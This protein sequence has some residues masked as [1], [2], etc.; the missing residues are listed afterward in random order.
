[1]VPPEAELKKKDVHEIM[2]EKHDSHIL[3]FLISLN[4]RQRWYFFKSQIMQAEL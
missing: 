3:N 2:S 4:G 1:M